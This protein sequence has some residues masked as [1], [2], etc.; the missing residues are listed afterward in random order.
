MSD[1]ISA[2]QDYRGLVEEIKK[3]PSIQLSSNAE[4]HVQR[5]ES[6]EKK[7]GCYFYSEVHDMGASIACCGLN[8]GLGNCPCE[9]CDK[10]LSKSDAFDIVLKHIRGEGRRKGQWQPRYNIFGVVFCSECGFELKINDTNYCPNCGAE[11]ERV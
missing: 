2:E 4:N 8:E 5:I 11:M 6:V 3:L 9:E 10:F 7:R 1:L